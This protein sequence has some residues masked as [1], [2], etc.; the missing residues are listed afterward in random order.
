MTLVK[1]FAYKGLTNVIYFFYFIRI[2][3]YIS[4]FPKFNNN[5]AW[6]IFLYISQHFPTFPKSI[7][8]RSWKHFYMFPRVS[9]N[10]KSL[11]YTENF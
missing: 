3:T 5:K 10:R 6:E 7:I 4:T 11:L 1:P 9:K 8:S 2:Y